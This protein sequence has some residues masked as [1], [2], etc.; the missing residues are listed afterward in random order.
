MTDA[1]TL[2]TA[3]HRTFDG[4][5]T[6]VA[7]QDAP[8]QDLVDQLV[9]ELAVHDAI[10]RQYLYPVLR[11]RID[12]GDR[13]ADRSIDEHDEQDRLLLDVDKTPSGSE[14]LGALI[15]TLT[16]SV[17]THVQE[18]ESEIFPALRAGLS[19]AELDD[20]GATLAKAKAKAP[21]RP[22]PHAPSEGTGTKVA[23][24]MSAPLDKARD[25][26]QGRNV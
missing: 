16:T 20:L 25:A 4:L 26:I 12:G 10:E 21:T 8:D 24:A 19:Q 15:A 3:D 18:E 13:F 2:L 7:G 6:Q 22:H 23:G 9:K 1:I 17:R 14:G 5:L 11:Q